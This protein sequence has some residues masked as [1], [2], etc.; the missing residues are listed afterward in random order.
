MDLSKTQSRIY[1]REFCPKERRLLVL[2]SSLVSI[3]RHILGLNSLI[4]HRSSLS[5]WDSV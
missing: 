1:S 4:V 2:K 5:E 3:I